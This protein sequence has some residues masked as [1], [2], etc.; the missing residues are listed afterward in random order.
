MLDLSGEEF[1]GGSDP[2][3]SLTPQSAD[4][5]VFFD[6]DEETASSRSN[7]YVKPTTRPPPLSPL[8]LNEE[9]IFSGVDPLPSRGTPTGDTA[10]AG[11]FK[12]TS[13]ADADEEN[14]PSSSRSNEYVRGSARPSPLATDE[15]FTGVDPLPSRGTPQSG[16]SA[17]GFWNEDSPQNT[18][19]KPPNLSGLAGG[20]PS[21][22]MPSLTPHPL[23]TDTDEQEGVS[24][25]R[26]NTYVGKDSR[27]EPLSPSDELFTGVDPL[28]SRGTPTPTGASAKKGFFKDDEEEEGKGKGKETVTS[29]GVQASSG[30]D[31]KSPGQDTE[32]EA[33]PMLTKQAAAVHHFLI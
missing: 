3:P 29:T 4:G 6:D 5:G 13:Y 11:F 24:S 2:M 1:N 32:A 23:N 9:S 33:H 12:E 22:P 14:R 19:P 28:P 21:D 15:L 18:Q 7:A 31:A 8:S 27:P 30:V 17:Q 10:E 25:S 26:N 20:A 16:D